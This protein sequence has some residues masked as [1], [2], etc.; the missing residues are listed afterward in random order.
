MGLFTFLEYVLIQ[1]QLSYFY[2]TEQLRPL[3]KALLV[4]GF[5]H[6][7]FWSVAQSLKHSATTPLLLLPCDQLT[8]LYHDLFLKDVTRNLEMS[9]YP[10]HCLILP[11]PVAY[12]WSEILRCLSWDF[13]GSLIQYIPQFIRSGM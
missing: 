11:P 2:T 6:K 13:F 12:G 1:S 9:Q 7:T 8:C 3:S 5:K 4:V 10:V